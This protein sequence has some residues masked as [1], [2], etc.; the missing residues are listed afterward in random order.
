MSHYKRKI[1][2]SLEEIIQKRRTRYEEKEILFISYGYYFIKREIEPII[3]ELRKK[4][5]SEPRE[6]RSETEDCEC[7]AQIIYH[8]SNIDEPCAASDT[9]VSSI[10]TNDRQNPVTKCTNYSV[11]LEICLESEIN[12]M[13]SVE[14]DAK[15]FIA[16]SV[17]SSN[18]SSS[19]YFWNRSFE[20]KVHH[21]HSNDHQIIETTFIGD[22]RIHFF[23]AGKRIQST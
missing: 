21:H 9:K 1:N 2:V 22:G 10:K 18:V 16:S 11:Y 3:K 14:T 15:S 6:R 8:H 20:E 19:I 5:Y 13:Y 12:P 17:I 4:C 23:K 7:E